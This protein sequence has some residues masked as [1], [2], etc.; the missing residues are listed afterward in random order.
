MASRYSI[1]QYVPNPIANERINIGVIVFDEEIVKVHF[2]RSWERINSFG[3]EDTKF[4]RDFAKRMDES[5]KNGLLFPN[6]D[7]NSGQSRVERLRNVSQEWINSIQFTEPRG[8]L[9]DIDSV[10]Q[11]VIRTYLV[12]KIPSQ[13]NIRDDQTSKKIGNSNVGSIPQ[14]QLR[15]RAIKSL[16]QE[17]EKGLIGS[18]VSC[19]PHIFTVNSPSK[20]GGSNDSQVQGFPLKPATN[21][22]GKTIV[23][24][25]ATTLFCGTFD[26]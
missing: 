23:G 21:K 25:Y 20:T 22:N 12:D 7:P 3:K 10:F 14:E 4:L 19:I 24:F 13:Q 18:H 2:L 26:Q 17:V 8:S 15:N 9:E 5:S 11:D 6:D 1:I 16:K